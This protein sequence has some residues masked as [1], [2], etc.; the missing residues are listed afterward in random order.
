MSKFT[1]SDFPPGVLSDSEILGLRK[2]DAAERRSPY[3]GNVRPATWLKLE[4]F[5]LVHHPFGD[6]QIRLTDLGR[7]VLTMHTARE[8]ARKE[9]ERR[10]AVLR[11][12]ASL[13][14]SYG[15]ECRGLSDEPERI[16][17][18]LETLAVSVEELRS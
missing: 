14:S 10:A 18:Q 3:P 17:S 11:E 12:A 2:C 7:E 16:A 1:A 15:P 13:V 8:S 5:E 4:K 9:L 6:G